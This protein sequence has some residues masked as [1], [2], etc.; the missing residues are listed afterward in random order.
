MWAFNICSSFSWQVNP[1]GTF[2][3]NF[4]SQLGTETASV[5]GIV[6]WRN[7]AGDTNNNLDIYGVT[8]VHRCY[9]ICLM[10]TEGNCWA[11]R[12]AVSTCVSK[13]V[14]RW[15]RH[16]LTI[17]LCKISSISCEFL[18]FVQKKSWPDKLI[19]M[20]SQYYC[21]ASTTG[22]MLMWHLSTC[23]WSRILPISVIGAY[24]RDIWLS[25]GWYLGI[26]NALLVLQIFTYDMSSAGIFISKITF[27]L[28]YFVNSKYWYLPIS[29]SVILAV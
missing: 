28:L 27:T 2:S 4:L 6:L 15:V 26:D 29:V 7:S 23:R 10:N 21:L 14:C 1:S 8:S 11:F 5:D 17:Q 12:W 13:I 9:Q 22:P 3:A 19:F 20:M 24:T 16:A 18:S 25:M